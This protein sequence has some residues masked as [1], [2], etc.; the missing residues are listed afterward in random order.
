MKIPHGKGFDLTG[1]LVITVV[2]DD[3][4]AL[5]GTFLGE[6]P[7]ER[8]FHKDE[9]HPKW[10]QEEPEFILLQLTC[11]FEE[12]GLPEIEAGTIVAINVEQI[13]FVFPGGVCTTEDP[14]K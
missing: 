3:R 2:L 6:I 9:C 14:Q 13:L 8:G 4:I 12:S 5:T 10:E 1:G 7:D 11:N